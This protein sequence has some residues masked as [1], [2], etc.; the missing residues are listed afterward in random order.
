MSKVLLTTKKIA[1]PLARVV[2]GVLLLDRVYA[3]ESLK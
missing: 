3:F 1:S 2:H